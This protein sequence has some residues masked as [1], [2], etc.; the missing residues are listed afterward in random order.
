MR[1]YI[2]I[3]TYFV[4]KWDSYQIFRLRKKITW[5]PGFQV[6]HRY[7]T[8]IR[9]IFGLFGSTKTQKIEV[10][11]H[12]QMGWIPIFGIP[13]WGHRFIYVSVQGMNE[14]YIS[15]NLSSSLAGLK[16]PADIF[17]LLCSCLCGQI[18]GKII[19]VFSVLLPKSHVLIISAMPQ[20]SQLHQ[21]GGLQEEILG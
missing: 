17:T 12:P 1:K 21:P 2:N 14:L 11:G 16:S 9:R 18:R 7:P 13:N 19:K 6:P 20:E 15:G 5:E 8:L 3:Y 4:K 10:H